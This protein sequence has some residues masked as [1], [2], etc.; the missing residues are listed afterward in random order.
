MM[1]R[2]S[3]KGKGKAAKEAPWSRSVQKEPSG[4]GVLHLRCPT[5]DAEAARFWSVGGSVPEDATASKGRPVRKLSNKLI[6][7]AGYSDGGKT[8]AAAAVPATK[9]PGGVD[10]VDKHSDDMAPAAAEEA[11]VGGEGEL[12]VLSPEL[13]KYILEWEPDPI[14]D[15]DEYYEEMTNDPLK[16]FSQEYIDLSV[17][18]LRDLAESSESINAEFRKFQAWARAEFQKKGRVEVDDN[19]IAQRVLF[20]QSMQEEWDAIMH[21]GPF[22]PAG[23]KVAG[24]R[25]S[26]P[27]GSN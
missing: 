4:E 7:A 3:T 5:M 2:G 26:A 20:R 27:I 22:L 12:T 19:F 21:Q 24:D 15:P 11:V 23:M 1:R 17:E 16:C 6:E 25:V 8:T 9:V 10:E 13:V 14:Q 18:I